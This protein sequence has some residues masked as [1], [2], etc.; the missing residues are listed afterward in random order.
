MWDGN[1]VHRECVAWVDSVETRVR[2]PANL[3]Q[4]RVYARDLLR[5]LP[6]ALTE[7]VVDYMGPEVRLDPRA[8]RELEIKD[9]MWGDFDRELRSSAFV[10]R[11]VA[12]VPLDDP[13]SNDRRPCNPPERLKF[14][15]KSGHQILYV[16]TI[17]HP[18]RD[19]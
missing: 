17:K 2:L 4:Y 5:R 13:Y 6:H 14:L 15:K 12:A 10:E 19:L 8:L 9:M 16:Q 18:P 3:V 11:F 1:G 7:L